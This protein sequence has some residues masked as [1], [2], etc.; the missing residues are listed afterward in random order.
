MNETGGTTTVGADGSAGDERSAEARSADGRS[1]KG[2][3]GDVASLWTI[4]RF[5]A[6][7]RW[8]STTV[9][10]VALVFFGAMM[11]AFGPQI[12]VE[13]G[14][15]DLIEAL[16]PAIR[17]AF[18]FEYL[19]SL[20]GL[21]A[22]EFYSIGWILL[23]GIYV[24]YAMAGTVAGDEDDDQLDLFL[25]APLSRTRL[26]AGKFLAILVPIVAVNV[27]VLLSLVGGVALIDETLPLGNLAALHAIS[28][29]YLLCVA[30]IGLLCS[31]LLD[32]VRTARRAAI[33]VV[34]VLWLFE[35]FL[36]GTD[37]EWLGAITP[38]RY[39]DPPAILVEGVVDPVAIGVLAGVTVVLFAAS[40]RQFRAGDVG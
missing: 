27:V 26:L 38:I 12:I 19:D 34:L 4:V 24:A 35:S 17:E 5:E 2:R 8:L 31:V 9:L 25:A 18:G 15:E 10:A 3:P 7:R 6:E 32:G 13:A 21:L 37:F 23:F 33:G 16:P 20:A 39:F 30:A 29:V 28:V 22:S 40:L 1:A 11:L 36:A 14:F